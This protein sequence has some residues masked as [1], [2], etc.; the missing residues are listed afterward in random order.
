MKK[1]IFSFV[2]LITTLSAHAE[3]LPA[4]TADTRMQVFD[5][6]TDDVFVIKTKIGHSSLIQFEEGETIHD[7]GGLGIGE[8]RDWSIAVK[9]NNVFFKPLQPSAPTNMIIVTNKRTY[10][11][12]LYS[13]VMD[14]MTYV[15]RF[16]YP[17]DKAEQKAP[18]KPM[19]ASF[20]R[21][22]QGEES[23]L[24]DAKI[25]TAYVKRGNLEITPTAMW[26]NGLFTY[27]QY[28]NAKELPT[29]Y[30][31]MPDGSEAIVNTHIEADTM[32]IHEVNHLYRLRLGKAVAELGNQKLRDNGF[33]HHGTSMS[34]FER[35]NK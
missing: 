4:F 31:V 30:K 16:N 18:A 20:Q 10:A 9:G 7:E 35:I 26:D 23:Y 13:T 15:A 14:D 6:R 27:L 5:Y 33:N 22:K 8:A 25:N 29:V 34:E 17:Q 1:L 12:A 11:F 3:Q 24:I 2:F 21:V 19:P 32:I 28:D